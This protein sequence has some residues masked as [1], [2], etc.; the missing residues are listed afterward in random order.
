M[1]LRF[2]ETRIMDMAAVQ[3]LANSIEERGQMVACIA[4]AEEPEGSMVLIHG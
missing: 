2:D 4:A 3:R 1:E